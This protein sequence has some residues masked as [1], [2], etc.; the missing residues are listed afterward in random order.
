VQSVADEI[1]SDRQ[2]PVHVGFLQIVFVSAKIKSVVCDAL[3][4]NAS[5]WLERTERLV[6]FSEFVTGYRSGTVRAH[7]DRGRA[8]RVCSDSPALP[9][10]YRT[11]HLIWKNISL[12]LVFGGLICLL[13]LPWWAGLGAAVLGV[14]IM[15]VAQKS[16][17]RSV[18]R[19]SLEDESFFQQMQEAGVLQVERP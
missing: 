9:R 6:N 11:A 13:W 10:R 8:M 12:L 18:L 5:R 3:T 4:T 19:Y 1:K 16:A 17:A 7:V 2:E 14:L 15:P